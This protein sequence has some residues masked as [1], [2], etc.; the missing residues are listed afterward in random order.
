MKNCKK[1]KW[2]NEKKNREM[3]CRLLLWFTVYLGMEKQ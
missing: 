1:K 2:K 3:H